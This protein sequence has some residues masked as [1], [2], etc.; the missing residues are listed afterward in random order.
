MGHTKKHEKEKCVP[1]IVHAI[2]FGPPSA[3]SEL[4]LFAFRCKDKE[5][6]FSEMSCYIYYKHG[7]MGKIYTTIEETTS[8]N[9]LYMKRSEKDKRVSQI[10]AK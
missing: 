9:E 7:G 6:F 3:A 2:V 1:P 10:I 8:K 4:Q 5:I